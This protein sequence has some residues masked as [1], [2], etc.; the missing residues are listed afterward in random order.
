MAKVGALSLFRR[1][2]TSTKG[3]LELMFSANALIVLLAQAGSFGPFEQVSNVMLVSSACSGL[4][5][6]QAV[7]LSIR[8]RRLKFWCSVLSGS[9]TLGVTDSILTRVWT[10][11]SATRVNHPAL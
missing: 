6:L 11:E 9:Q 3:T 5:A 8:Y 10:R 1:A 2:R 4:T 7:R